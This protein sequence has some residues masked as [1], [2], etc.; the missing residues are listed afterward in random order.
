MLSTPPLGP[1]VWRDRCPA[2]LVSGLTSSKLQGASSPAVVRLKEP[3][4]RT[5]YVIV[6][7]LLMGTLGLLE[8]ATFPRF[9]LIAPTVSD[10]VSGYDADRPNSV[11]TFDGMH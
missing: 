3:A 2:P 9:P 11:G 10:A 5:L 1:Y 6:T 4:M 8:F 7:A